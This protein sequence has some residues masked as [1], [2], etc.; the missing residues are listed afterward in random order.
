MSEVVTI[1]QKLS[2]EVE[3]SVYQVYCDCGENLDFSVSVDRDNDLI[4]NVA[5]HECQNNDDEDE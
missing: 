2:V 1:E 3:V 5:E 4:V